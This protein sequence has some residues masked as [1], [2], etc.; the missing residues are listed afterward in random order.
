MTTI[1]AIIRTAHSGEAVELAILENVQRADLNPI[2]EA[3][4]YRQ[5]LDEHRYTQ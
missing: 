1:A 5:L 4:G 3:A 2:E